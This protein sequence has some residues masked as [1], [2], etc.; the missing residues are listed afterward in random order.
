MT[1]HLLFFL[2]QGGAKSGFP[3]NHSLSGNLTSRVFGAKASNYDLHVWSCVPY[4]FPLISR[5]IVV[6]RFALDDLFRLHF[7]V[8]AGAF[9]WWKL[10]DVDNVRLIHDDCLGT[11]VCGLKF[12]NLAQ[13]EDGINLDRL[14]MA[15]FLIID[16]LRFFIRGRIQIINRLFRSDIWEIFWRM[17]LSWNFLLIR[18][19]Y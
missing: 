13:L 4:G 17:I 2:R 19:I 3:F 1:C 7:E 18:R 11:L 8:P 9:P 10:Q 12:L 14:L 6:V 16:F 15:N 5:M